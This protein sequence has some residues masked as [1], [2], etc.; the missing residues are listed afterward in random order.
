MTIVVIAIV[1]VVVA[2]A[3][4]A[5]EFQRFEGYQRDRVRIDHRLEP[6]SGGGTGLLRPLSWTM[7]LSALRG[8]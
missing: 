3:D 2:A 4:Y 8:Q 6:G 7:D 1:V 5:L